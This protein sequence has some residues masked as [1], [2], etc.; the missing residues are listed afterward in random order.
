VNAIIAGG[1]SGGNTPLVLIWFGLFFLGLLFIANAL[2]SD[3]KDRTKDDSITDLDKVRNLPLRHVKEAI[4]RRPPGASTDA[5]DPG[6]KGPKS[7]S[8]SGRSRGPLG[9]VK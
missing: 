8:I 1:Y 3:A 5:E 6:S 9:L 2:R 7:R 4:Y